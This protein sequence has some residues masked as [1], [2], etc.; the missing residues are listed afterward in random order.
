MN[1]CRVYQLENFPRGRDLLSWIKVEYHFHGTEELPLEWKTDRGLSVWHP[2]TNTLTQRALASQPSLFL[3]ALSSALKTLEKFA[4][5]LVQKRTNLHYSKKFKGY[6][7]YGSVTSTPF[8]GLVLKI[9]NVFSNGDVI[10]NYD[11][12]ISTQ[13]LKSRTSLPQSYFTDQTLLN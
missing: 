6:K 13:N 1:E 2:R 9:F 7:Q 11:V 10:A 5:E 8:W 3:R 4:Q 12:I